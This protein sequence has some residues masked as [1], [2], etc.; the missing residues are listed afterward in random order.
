[1]LAVLLHLAEQ[2]LLLLSQAIPI[3]LS[4]PAEFL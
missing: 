1:V 2:F 3:L 4:T